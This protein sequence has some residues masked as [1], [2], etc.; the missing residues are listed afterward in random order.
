MVV[1]IHTSEKNAHILLP[2]DP[3]EIEMKTEK[4]CIFVRV[5]TDVFDW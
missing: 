2:S 3:L 1:D 4:I 5:A